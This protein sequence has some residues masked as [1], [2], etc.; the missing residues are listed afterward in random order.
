MLGS[1]AFPESVRQTENAFYQS[2]ANA[3]GIPLDN[4]H[5]FQKSDWFSWMGALAFDNPQQ[6]S[7][8]IDFLYQFANTS[9]D[10]QPFSDFYDTTTNRLPGGFIARFV[11]GGLY[12]IPILN[13]AAKGE[14]P[15]IDFLSGDNIRAIGQLATAESRR[16]M[17]ALQE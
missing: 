1:S 3:Y 13:A 8:I 14:W 16:S 17:S 9:P 2:Q 7:A 5:T 4:R 6:Q 10:R 11:M 15:A 12:S